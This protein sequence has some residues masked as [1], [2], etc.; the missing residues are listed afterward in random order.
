MTL[1]EKVAY[2][3][4]LAEGLDLDKDAKET[5]IFN[6]MFDLLEDLALTV[7]DIDEDL[8]ACEDMV[9]A[10]DA[11]LEDL[12]DYIFEDDCDCCDDDD[13]CCCDDDELY[14]VEC[15][16]CGEEIL[17]DEEMLDEEIIEC[18][19]CGEKL[20]LDIDF[21][22]CDCDCDCGCDCCDEDDE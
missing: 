4:G 19:G 5:K 13:C 15:P 2:L 7:S 10:I 17:L 16:L 20:E 22:D 18:P 12:E 8:G 6:A 14:E 11:D 3:K 21:D 9:D 1:T